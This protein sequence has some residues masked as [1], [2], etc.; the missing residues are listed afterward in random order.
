MI[1]T[2]ISAPSE[3]NNKA[4]LIK[5]YAQLCYQA[6]RQGADII[7]LPELSFE[8]TKPKSFEEASDNSDE[9]GGLDITQLL[10]ISEVYQ[11]TIVYGYIETDNSL[12][13]NSSCVLHAGKVVSNY[14][15]INLSGPDYLWASQNNSLISHS[16]IVFRDFRMGVLIGDDILNYEEYDDRKKPFYN[17]NIDVICCLI[18][19]EIK[20]YPEKSWIHLVKT[21]GANII[22]SNKRG[23]SCVITRLLKVYTES[24]NEKNII[25]GIIQI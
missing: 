21:T 7:V 2:S 23:S 4:E 14:K 12:L 22:V 10:R 5:T 3:I 8:A 20:E 11:N 15:K 13:Y 25:G 6:S 1:V 24:L 17:G 18:D 19:K 9:P 16:P